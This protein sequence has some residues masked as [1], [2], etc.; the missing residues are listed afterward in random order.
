MI[1]RFFV[2]FV[3][4]FSLAAQSAEII[5]ANNEFKIFIKDFNSLSNEENLQKWKSIEEKY[6]QV[7]SP[8]VFPRDSKNWQQNRAAKLN[9]FF[10]MLPVLHDRM[11]KIFDEAES[12][13]QKQIQKFQ[14]INKDFNSDIKIYFLPSAL[15]FNGRVVTLPTDSG[16]YSLLIGVDGLVYWNND[17]EVLFAHELF[18]YY[19][20][21]KNSAIKD[22]KSNFAPFWTEGMAAYYSHKNLPEKDLSQIMMDP[23]L[24]KACESD[25]YVKGLAK[26]LA[27]VVDASMS[28]VEQNQFM[29]EWFWMNGRAKPH[30][31]AYCLG[32]RVVESLSQKYSIQ[33]MISW[34][35][36]VMI[37]NF[38]SA[39]N[40]LAN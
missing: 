16:K 31:P 34:N 6:D 23:E 7:Y 20:F 8:V 2:I 1:P 14:S 39:L 38:N 10:T 29:S 35:E 28:A 18:H 33:E 11:L 37:L 12:I 19:H 21:N 4:F 32:F 30:R 40:E 36:E 17:I 22:F 9:L 5:N 3:M 27:L 26:K 13:A 15:T 25:V 24:G